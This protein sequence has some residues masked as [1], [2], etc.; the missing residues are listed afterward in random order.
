MLPAGQ[1]PGS[2]CGK[3]HSLAED[4]SR[5]IAEPAQPLQVAPGSH[6][7]ARRWEMEGKGSAESR[8]DERWGQGEKPQGLSPF[9]HAPFF[10]RVLL[11]THQLSLGGATSHSG[12]W[13]CSFP[14]PPC[15]QR[16]NLCHHLRPDVS[17]SQQKVCL[18]SLLPDIKRTNS[19][20]EIPNSSRNCTCGAQH[21][22][23]GSCPEGRE[24]Q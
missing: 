17:T 10:L 19:R 6:F 15:K 7:G 22:I 9:H 3:S 8:E 4:F 5:A 12:F 18:K 13:S 20:G 14:N 16:W 23:A 1:S 2:S 11:G 21:T 24:Q